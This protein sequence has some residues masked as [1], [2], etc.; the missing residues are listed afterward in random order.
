MIQSQ[1]A[2][3][4]LKLFGYAV[5]AAVSMETTSAST[6]GQADGLTVVLA[7]TGMCCLPIVKTRCLRKLVYV[8]EGVAAIVVSGSHS[9]F[10]I[11]KCSSISSY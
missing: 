9:R 6:G 3:G 5:G 10:T 4:K 7:I 2:G 11:W 1:P 8:V